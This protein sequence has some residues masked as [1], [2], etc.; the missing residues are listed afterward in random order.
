MKSKAKY[1]LVF[2]G[3]LVVLIL[4]IYQ[5]LETEDLTF[6]D[7]KNMDTRPATPV[8]PLPSRQPQSRLPKDVEAY[9]PLDDSSGPTSNSNASAISKESSGFEV[10]EPPSDPQESP[11]DVTQT[12]LGSGGS[13]IRLPASLSQ[14]QGVLDSNPQIIDQAGIYLNSHGGTGT[15]ENALIDRGYE[16][17]LGRPATASEQLE[18]AQLLQQLKNQ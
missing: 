9:L 7:P 6:P 10:S 11:S 16:K 14:Y 8:R 1:F 12:P 5:L 15:T 3:V 2:S 4:P 17:Y 18:G 13:R